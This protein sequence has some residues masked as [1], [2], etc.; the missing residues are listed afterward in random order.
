MSWLSSLV[1]SVFVTRY[2]IIEHNDSVKES[3]LPQ[4]ATSSSMTPIEIYNYEDKLIVGNQSEPCTWSIGRETY[5]YAGHCPWVPKKFV[6]CDFLPRIVHPQFKNLG[7]YCKPP[8][9]HCP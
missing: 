7:L 4:A 1:A 5:Y 9:D 3:I 2:V 8:D 6:Q